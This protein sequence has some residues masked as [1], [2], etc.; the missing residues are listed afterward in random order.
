MSFT[1]GSA[2]ISDFD[3][4]HHSRG[5][6]FIPT[7]NMTVSALGY[8]DQGADGL[9]DAHIVGIF[10]GDTLVRSANIPAGTVARLTGSFR[11]AEVSTLELT[12]GNVYT[13]AGTSGLDPWA[14]AFTDLNFDPRVAG[15]STGYYTFSDPYTLARPA[16]SFGYQHYAGPNFEFTAAAEASSVP[17]PASLL[18]LLT[19]LGLIVSLRGRRGL[20]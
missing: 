13:I 18:L 7:V 19:A 20:G 1:A 12:A 9:Q 16:S 10:D 6:R 5:F 4:L 17:E 15:S 2:T 3:E 11:Y 14:Y 8:F